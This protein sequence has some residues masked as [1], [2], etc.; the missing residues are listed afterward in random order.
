MLHVE[1]VVLWHSSTKAE[2]LS[3]P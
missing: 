2:F 1:P 3:G